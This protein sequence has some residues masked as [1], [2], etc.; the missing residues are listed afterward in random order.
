MVASLCL[1]ALCWSTCYKA[2][3]IS[4]ISLFFLK[5]LIYLFMRHTEGEAET[6]AEG[7]A[8]S[9]QDSILNLQDHDPSRRQALNHWAIQ[10]SLLSSLLSLFFLSSPTFCK[11]SKSIIFSEMKFLTPPFPLFPYSISHQ[12]LWILSLLFCVFMPG[13]HSVSFI[14]AN[15]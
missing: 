2:N 14:P 11:F 9:L 1:T 15:R 7:E 4:L 13:W 8:G 12:V 5:D 3:H 10:A 6:Q